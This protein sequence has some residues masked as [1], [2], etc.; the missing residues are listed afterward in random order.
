MKTVSLISIVLFSMIAPFAA[1]WAGQ[2]IAEASPSGFQDLA[3]LGLP[4]VFL[5]T[6]TCNVYVVRQGDRAILVDLG[7]GT[8]L[9]HLQ[10]IGIRKVDWVLFTHHHREQNQGYPSLKRWQPRIGGPE[11]ERALFEQPLEFRKMNPSLRDAFT[12]HGSSYVRPPLQPI[13]LDRAFAKMDTFD[14]QGREFWCLDTRGNSPGSMSYLLHDDGGRLVAFSGDV[15]LDG[16]RM[17]NWFDTEWDYGFAAGIYA[18]HGSAALLADHGLSLLLP[19]HGPVIQEPTAQL[20]IFQE[21]LR[22]LA[23]TLIRGYPAG[24]FSSADQDRVSRPTKVPNVWQVSEHVFKLKGP[25]YSPNFT[26]ILADSGHGLMVDCGLIDPAFLDRTIELMKQ[27]LG[28]KQIDAV[29]FSHMHGDH[30]LQAP[31]LREKWGTKIWVLDRMAAQV[32]HPEWFDYAAPVEAYGQGIDGIKPDRILRSGETFDWEGYHLTSDWM[33]GQTEFAMG[34]HG[35]IDGRTVVFTGDNLFAN[36]EDPSQDG[37][38]AVVAH[39]SSIL[40]EGYIYGAQFLARIQPDL[41]IGGHSWVMDNPAQ[42]IGRYQDWAFRMRTAF[43]ALANDEDYR[44]WYDPFWVRAEPYRVRLAPAKGLQVSL[45]VRNFRDRPQRHHIE[46]HTAGGLSVD[47]RIIEG[48]VAAKSSI[49]LPLRLQA[50]P[51]AEGKTM[52]AFDVTLDGRRYGEW[53]DMIVEVRGDSP[54]VPK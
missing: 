43:Q 14:W 54:A 16:A 15:M 47:P 19:S 39:N 9:E 26:L 24:T 12:I 36:P 4:D 40:E 45:H 51:G 10:E 46:I 32:E 48:S 27:R 44:Y 2:S 30:M 3:P 35:L 41:L 11:A 38:E 33:P 20:R 13:R 18:L 28:L 42:L 31:H 7:D 5:W 25:N 52:V 23:Q 37:H 6:D 22:A 29:L 50:S 49:I 1:N 17:H 53:F 8:V 34:L 21:K